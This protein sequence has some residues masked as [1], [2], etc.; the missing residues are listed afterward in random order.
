MSHSE[1]NQQTVSRREAL[2]VLTA[3]G[4]AMALSTL[5]DKWE[6]PMVQVGALPALAQTSPVPSIISSLVINGPLGPCDPGGGQSGDLFTAS[7]NYS[8]PDSDVLADQARVRTSFEFSPSG[9]VSTQEATL[10]AANIT[11]DSDSGSINVP[12]CI[13]F[14]AEAS[15]TLA[16]SLIDAHGLESNPE[17]GSIPNPG[18][19]RSGV[20]P[21]VT[22]MTK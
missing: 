14:G 4:G 12:L 20:A 11:G 1:S 5:P 18:L 8:D 21:Q 16:I 10:S 7:F 3:A 13:G 2:K 6:T 9:A 22:L 17:T 19:P 15:V